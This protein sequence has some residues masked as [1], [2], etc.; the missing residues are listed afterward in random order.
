MSLT[1]YYHPLASFCHKVLIAL[2][3]NETAFER[4]IIN[5]GEPADR[6][7]LEAIWP[8]CR[9]PVLRDHARGVDVP[10]TSIIIE[11]LDRHY[12]GA[13]PMLP[14]DPDVALDVRLWDRF[15]DHYVQEPMQSI[16]LARLNDTQ[17]DLTSDRTKLKT[18][19]KMIE[20][21]MDARVWMCGASFS[22]ADCAAAPALFYAATVLPFPE[23]Y[24]ALNT[25]FDRL[26]ARPSVQRVL[27]EAKP[28]FRMYPFY[29][30]IPE[31]FL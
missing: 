13:Q 18:A 6:A 12:P 21:R 30:D 22:L 4:R 20:K 9:F 25:Y 7:E 14:P 28:Y 16:V 8:L 31:R 15:F 27:E 17:C 10:E 23:E 11:Y 26:M 19:Y 5:L 2:Y 3:E 1:L 24:D 29:D